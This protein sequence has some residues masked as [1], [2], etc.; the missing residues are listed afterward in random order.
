[1]FSNSVFQLCFSLL[2]SEISIG[3]P[4]SKTPQETVP[5]QKLDPPA[6]CTDSQV[7]G[8]SCDQ[9]GGFNKKCRGQCNDG[10]AAVLVLNDMS[11]EAE[12]V[13]AD[14]GKTVKI[15]NAGTVA[16]VQA[17]WKIKASS[18]LPDSVLESV[19]GIE[20]VP[21]KKIFDCIEG[22]ATFSRCQAAEL[23][24]EFFKPLKIMVVNSNSF[25]DRSGVK[26][27]TLMDNMRGLIEI[28]QESAVLDA[29][30]DYELETA[31]ISKADG[32]RDQNAKTGKSI[33][34][35]E[36][37]KGKPV[38]ILLVRNHQFQLFLFFFCVVLFTHS[39]P[40]YYIKL[41]ITD[42]FPILFFFCIEG[43]EQNASTYGFQPS[44]GKLSQSKIVS[45][46]C[47]DFKR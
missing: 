29:A 37:G 15:A 38:D 36:D 33:V 47:F 4:C 11:Q 12:A 9:H 19:V 8:L 40:F 6:D 14:P 28:T 13:L 39:F 32:T 27:L 2:T 10:T 16:T 5:P 3:G 22:D 44:Y 21:Q 7:A 25:M 26:K 35:E 34:G 20:I 41:Y 30:Y 42:I 17:E 23:N 18:C 24:Q 45:L 43:I 31:G 46:R 1:M